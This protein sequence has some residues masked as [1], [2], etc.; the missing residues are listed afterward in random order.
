MRLVGANRSGYSMQMLAGV[1]IDLGRHPPVPVLVKL[2]LNVLLRAPHNRVQS[3]SG[4]IFRLICRQI[5]RLGLGEAAECH[6]LHVCAAARQPG[7]ALVVLAAR[8]S[9]M[10]NAQS[11]RHAG[12]PDERGLKAAVSWG[13]CLGMGM[14]CR[15]NYLLRRYV[16]ADGRGAQ[17]GR[18]SFPRSKPYVVAKDLFRTCDEFKFSRFRLRRDLPCRPCCTGK[19]ADDLSQTETQGIFGN[20]RACRER[21]KRGVCLF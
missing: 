20:E 9:D 16:H 14:R 19:L 13:Y 21:L 11:A 4:T 5:L 17:T 8:W 3:A 1:R 6:R 2:P 12:P 7:L 10:E 15:R 18:D